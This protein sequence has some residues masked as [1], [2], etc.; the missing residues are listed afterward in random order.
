[1]QTHN[2]DNTEKLHCSDHFINDFSTPDRVKNGQNK[3]LNWINT[4]KI[5][6]K[7][8]IKILFF[9]HIA[10]FIVNSIPMSVF[11]S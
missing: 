7:L 2:Y 6:V 10:A 4:A 11:S 9:L 8:K 3:W 1:M 5:P